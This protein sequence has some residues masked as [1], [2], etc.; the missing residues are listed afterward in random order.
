MAHCGRGREK[1]VAVNLRWGIFIF[2]R[3]FPSPPPPSAHPCGCCRCSRA[4]DKRSE[5]W[6]RPAVV[7]PPSSN[8][9]S[10]PCTR[11][12]RRAGAAAGQ[13]W[14]L[15]RPCE[16]Q[17]AQTSCA[18]RPRWFLPGQSK[19][20]TDGKSA[21]RALVYPVFDTLNIALSGYYYR[22]RLKFFGE[23]FDKDSDK[24]HLQKGGWR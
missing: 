24:K 22:A 5:A 2:T 4:A 10:S 12:G 13:S 3:T 8:L 14:T 16:W 9:S 15:R 20:H 21:R 1:N 19:S 7:L 17:Q 23:M 18:G 11:P 6:L